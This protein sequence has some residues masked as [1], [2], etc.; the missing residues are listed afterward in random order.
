VCCLC[1]FAGVRCWSPCW[2]LVGVAAGVGCSCVRPDTTTRQPAMGVCCCVL[3]NLF[4]MSCGCCPNAAWRWCHTHQKHLHVQGAQCQCR[5]VPSACPHVQD[6]ARTLAVPASDTVREACC[7]PV[8]CLLL[9]RG[10]C[11]EL[12]CCAPVCWLRV[13]P[14]RVA[15]AAHRPHHTRDMLCR[16][17]VVYTTLHLLSILSCPVQWAHYLVAL[18]LHLAPDVSTTGPIQ[19]RSGTVS[20]SRSQ[21]HVPSIKRA[22]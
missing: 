8:L 6:T 1:W 3:G 16:S 10:F 7:S 4:P 21:K 14:G 5:G 12:L 18:V 15:S 19:H 13:E 17:T 20:S 9:W 2:L 11:F 22:F